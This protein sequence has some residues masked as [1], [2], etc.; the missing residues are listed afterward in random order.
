MSQPSYLCPWWHRVDL[1][2]RHSG[3]EPLALPLSYGA[4]QVRRS[5]RVPSVTRRYDSEKERRRQEGFFAEKS[6]CLNGSP[7]DPTQ[8]LRAVESRFSQEAARDGVLRGGPC[9]RGP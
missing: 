2:H 7:D 6:L 9:P 4:R 8:Y 5:D 3:Y 1:N